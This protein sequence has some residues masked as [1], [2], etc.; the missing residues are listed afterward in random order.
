MHIFENV[1]I[2][3][4]INIEYNEDAGELYV[5]I[6]MSEEQRQE[7]IDSLHDDMFQNDF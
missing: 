3:Q 5:D 4:I 7:L 2:K 6:P 1:D